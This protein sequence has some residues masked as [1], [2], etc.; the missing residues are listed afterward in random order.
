MFPR[1]I[2]CHGVDGDVLRGGVYAFPQYH[3]PLYLN[4]QQEQRQ[5]AESCP[6]GVEQAV[7][8]SVCAAVPGPGLAVLLCGLN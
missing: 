8:L 7:L 1:V 6:G 3:R 5:W 4:S 2:V